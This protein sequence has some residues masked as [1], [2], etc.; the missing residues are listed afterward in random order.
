ME[1][2]SIIML[3]SPI[4]GLMIFKPK[5]SDNI[6]NKIVAKI[7]IIF[8]THLL[9]LF[10]IYVLKN[11]D[12]IFYTNSFIIKYSLLAML[13]SVLISLVMIILYDRLSLRQE[14]NEKN[15]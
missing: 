7:S 6:I 4:V 3:L 12:Y 15:C 14:K 11:L 10:S 1:T 2:L 8:W 9:T 13:Y 5:K